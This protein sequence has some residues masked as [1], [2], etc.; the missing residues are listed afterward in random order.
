MRLQQIHNWGVG[1]GTVD[2][3]LSEISSADEKWK[4][5]DKKSQPQKQ[6]API[7][8]ANRPDEV[9]EADAF[10]VSEVTHA[11]KAGEVTKIGVDRPPLTRRPERS[12]AMQG[13]QEYSKQGLQ[14]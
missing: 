14:C 3:N 5:E 8:Q 4:D 2:Q 7:T 12:G 6:V 10:L 11:D 13:K 1:R 9:A